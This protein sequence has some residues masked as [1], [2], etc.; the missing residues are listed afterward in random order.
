MTVPLAVNQRAEWAVIASI[1][2][3]GDASFVQKLVTL[4]VCADHFYWS[5]NGALFS[6]AVKIAGRNG[7]SDVITLHAEQ[8]C[9]PRW[10]QDEIEEI[11]A[12]VPVAGHFAEYAKIVRELA[13]WRDRWVTVLNLREAY[14]NRDVE[15]WERVYG[16][17]VLAEPEPVML[18]VPGKS[19]PHLR[20]VDK[21]TGEIVEP[22]TCEE[23]QKTQ[24]QLAG[25]QSEIRSWRAKYA[26]LARDKEA[27]AK[28]SP[29]WKQGEAL[30]D[31]W[32]DLAKHP[33]SAWTPDRFFICEP[34][35]R[36]KKYGLAKCELAIAG[37]SYDP[38]KRVQRNGRMHFY[39]EFQRAFKSPDDF[40][41]WANRS[42]IGYVPSLNADELLAKPVAVADAMGVVPAVEVASAGA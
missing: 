2:H 12:H 28:A 9:D 25:A 36:N 39:N 14:V 29:W 27:E 37:L 40:E 20:L 34:Y 41:G 19:V 15:A 7:R 31:L 23:C 17:P 26:I 1:L 32:R 10:E 42:P 30:F 38:Y 4:G 13:E 22:T 11:A 3:H 8:D 6:A 5:R 21:E 16:Q 18:D 24:D 35:L 33:R